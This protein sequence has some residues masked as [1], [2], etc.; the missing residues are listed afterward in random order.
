L[1]FTQTLA[2]QCRFASIMSKIFVHLKGGRFSMN[3]MGHRDFGQSPLVKWFSQLV[4]A[5][6]SA[7]SEHKVVESWKSRNSNFLKSKIRLAKRLRQLRCLKTL[8]AQD[9][10]IIELSL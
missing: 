7:A 4:N 5:T 10:L 9:E 6:A 2:I 3:E 8:E 1:I